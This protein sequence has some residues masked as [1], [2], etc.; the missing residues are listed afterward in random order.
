M[1]IWNNNALF[2]FPFLVKHT[3]SAAIKSLAWWHASLFGEYVEWTIRFHSP[4]HL[5]KTLRLNLP[6]LSPFP[7][8][9]LLLATMQRTRNEDAADFQYCWLPAN[10]NVP[11]NCLKIAFTA[12]TVDL[13][14]KTWAAEFRHVLYRLFTTLMRNGR[15]YAMRRRRYLSLSSSFYLLSS[16]CHP[17]TFRTLTLV[18]NLFQLFPWYL[19]F[20]FKRHV[21]R[22]K[23]GSYDKTQQIWL[24]H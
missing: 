3:G 16:I 20:P 6:P 14:H 23:R 7:T 2:F 5:N 10:P 17:L 9:L 24:C 12:E 8:T 18:C 1:K 19:N 21:L 13:A 22:L 4:T 15:R 11:F